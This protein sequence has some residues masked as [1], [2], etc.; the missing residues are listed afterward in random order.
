MKTRHT[1][2]SRGIHYAPVPP[3]CIPAIGCQ[4][5]GQGVTPGR[6]TFCSTACEDDFDSRHSP[7][8]ANRRALESAETY[9]LRGD[10]LGY[11]C[12][13]CGRIYPNIRA[14]RVRHRQGRLQP[15]GCANHPEHLAVSCAGCQ[16]RP[17]AQAGYR[18]AAFAIA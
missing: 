7:I 6:L 12:W 13:D 4:N 18:Q 5:C 8:T 14:V 15:F 3:D 11:A 16:Y 2:R 1:R 17:L 10:F 9:S